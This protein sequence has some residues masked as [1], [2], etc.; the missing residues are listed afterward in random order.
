MKRSRGIVGLL[1]LVLVFGSITTASAIILV[2]VLEL[3][4]L[5]AIV[6]LTF[7]TYADVRAVPDPPGEIAA[8]DIVIEILDE[9]GQA[10]DT[11]QARVPAGEIVS[12][13]YRSR[14][15]PGETDAIRATVKSRTVPQRPPP[16]GPCPIL[17]SLQVIDASS[18]KTEAMMMPAVQRVV[19]EVI[20]AP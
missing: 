12:L 2:T 11:R 7:D 4:T 16:P 8:C 19:R 9:H 17:A 10:L 13:Q 5:F 15:G 20:P 6:G 3:L 14:R 18:G 1:P